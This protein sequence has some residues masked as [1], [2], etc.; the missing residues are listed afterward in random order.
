M[1]AEKEVTLVT[2][3][4]DIGRKDFKTIPRTNE[5]YLEYFRV[6]AKMKNKLIVY[7]NS[8]MAQEVRKEREKWNLLDKTIIIE[9]NN[10]TEIEPQIL[11]RLKEVS[12]N[13]YFLNY[14]MKQNAVSNNPHY[15]Y[16][17]MLKYWCLAN[18]V[19]EHYIDREEMVAWIDFGFNHGTA[20]YDKPE[21]FNFLWTTSLPDDKIHL[22][23]LGEISQ[24]PIF[25]L[26]R[27]LEDSIMGCLILLPAS[28]CQEFWRAC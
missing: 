25:H 22:F 14:R 13:P 26:V 16:V 3:F 2:A 28:L 6:W 19:E 17:M 9:I 18:A 5:Q 12:E 20:C 4:F 11:Q 27:T 24:K 8:K 1:K 21:E 15:D 23:T 10:E 7:T